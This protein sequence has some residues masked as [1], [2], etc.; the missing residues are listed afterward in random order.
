MTYVTTERRGGVQVIRYGNPPHGYLCRAGCAELRQAFDACARDPDLRVIIFTGA[1]DAAFIH[2]FDIAEII[3]AGEA[4]T[5]GL[6]GPD[7]FDGGDFSALLT[8]IASSPK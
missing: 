2:H 3:S 5:A 7:V 8:G 6:V 4:I 1:S